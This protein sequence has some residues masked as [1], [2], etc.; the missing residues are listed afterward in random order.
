MAL[1]RTKCE[2]VDAIQFTGGE[3]P[4]GDATLPAWLVAANGKQAGQPGAVVLLAHKPDAGLT[5]F[6]ASGAAFLVNPGEWLIQRSSGE[7]EHVTAA[8]LSE[9]FEAA[10]FP[11]ETHAA[12]LQAKLTL[13][14]T[15]LDEMRQRH[16][17]EI[18]GK[19]ADI[20]A[21][22]EDIAALQARFLAGVDVK[23]ADLIG[24][25]LGT[26]G[27]AL[28]AAVAKIA[29]GE[30]LTERERDIVSLDVTA[31]LRR[32]VDASEAGKS[33]TGSGSFLSKGPALP[34]AGRVVLFIAA[35][36]GLMGSSQ[37]PVPAVITRVI[38]R[39][40]VNLTVFRDEAEPISVRAVP[41][42]E[43]AAADAPTAWMW[44]PRV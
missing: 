31:G 16:A 20:A 12:D 44:P 29:A 8:D 3:T 11:E 33:Q 30:K 34:S 2:Y 18:A 21:R 7:L 6:G 39:D 38:E 41:F 32:A 25:D 37:E 28:D 26:E 5:Y 36:A 43:A 15:E 27:V 35:N 23:Q 1:Y 13:A 14:L 19:D 9:Y 17:G 10:P 42:I 24:I 4:F 22:D 40:L